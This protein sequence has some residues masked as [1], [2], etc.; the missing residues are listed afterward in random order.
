MGIRILWCCEIS[1]YNFGYGWWE[2]VVIEEV[3]NGDGCGDGEGCSCELLC[4]LYLVLWGVEGGK[5]GFV[6]VV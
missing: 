4:C 3:S 5:D 6:G 2:G 1:F